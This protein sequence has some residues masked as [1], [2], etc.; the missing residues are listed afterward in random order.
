MRPIAIL[1][2]TLYS[3]GIVPAYQTARYGAEHCKEPPEH[4]VVMP[5]L[6]AVAWPILAVIIGI[7][8]VMTGGR[9]VL[10]CGDR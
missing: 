3:L 2:L 10:V 6:L 4:S 5:T 1:A 7:G 9:T 8:T